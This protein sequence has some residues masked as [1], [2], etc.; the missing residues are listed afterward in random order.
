MEQTYF[1]KGLGLKQEV[2]GALSADYHSR[3]V[4]QVREQNNQLSAGGLTFKLAQE[5]GFSWNIGESTIVGIDCPRDISLVLQPE[6]AIFLG[7]QVRAF[8]RI[9]THISCRGAY[10]LVH[11]SVRGGLYGPETDRVRGS[12]KGSTSPYFL[13]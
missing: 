12:G 2:A 7:Q 4:D 1:R 6:G 9:A 13:L 10:E 8:L 5:F 3:L 11:S